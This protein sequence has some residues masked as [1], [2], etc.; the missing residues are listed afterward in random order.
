MKQLQVLFRTYFTGREKEHDLPF[1]FHLLL[2]FTLLLQIRQT[3]E[4]A[5][6]QR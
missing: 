5:S 3:T 6:V 4:L 2:Y 1:L